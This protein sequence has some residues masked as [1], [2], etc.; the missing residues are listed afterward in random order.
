MELRGTGISAHQSRE[1]W[2]TGVQLTSLRRCTGNEKPFI[3]QILELFGVHLFTDASVHI[4]GGSVG[5][6]SARNVRDLGSV[7]GL[8]RSPGEGNGHPLQYSCLED[9]MDGGAWWATVHGVTKTWT[10]LSDFTFTFYLMPRPGLM[11]EKVLELFEIPHCDRTWQN[12]RNEASKCKAFSWSD[13]KPV[14]II[15][16]CFTMSIC[17]INEASLVAQR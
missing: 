3:L 9:S 7:P 10:W 5:K 2:E 14:I 11:A 6:A 13:A 1:T 15:G 16:H 17:N 8:G 12:K 4:S